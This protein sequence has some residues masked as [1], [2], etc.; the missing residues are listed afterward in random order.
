M[1]RGGAI[2]RDKIIWIPLQNTGIAYAMIG[3][4]KYNVELV[5]PANVSDE[6]KKAL[7]PMT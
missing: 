2:T 7:K 6:R 1:G 4:I 3:A 5:V